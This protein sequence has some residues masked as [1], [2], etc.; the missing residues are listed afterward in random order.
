M[1]PPPRPPFDDALLDTVTLIA[2]SIE[3]RDQATG[4]HSFRTT[5]YALLLAERAGL[6]PGDVVLLRVGTPLHDLGKIGIDD[7]VLRKPGPLTAAEFEAMK[8]HA[9]KGAEIL[10]TVLGLQPIRPLVRS[11]HERWD[12]R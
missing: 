7:A 10:E 3:L 5:T 2:Q 6:P 12:G 4:N 9:V 1:K 11:H 8:A